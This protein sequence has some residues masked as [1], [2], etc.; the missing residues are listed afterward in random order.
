MPGE[1]Q[2]DFT[3]TPLKDRPISRLNSHHF[4]GWF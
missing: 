2:G 4:L 3:T 1:K